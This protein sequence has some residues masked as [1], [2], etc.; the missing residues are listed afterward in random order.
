MSEMKTPIKTLNGH[1]LEDTEARAK[2]NQLSEEID[3]LKGNGGGVLTV[4]VQSISTFVAEA[5]PTYVADKTFAEIEAAFSAG[6][7]VIAKSEYNVLP[8]L[9]FAPG[10]AAMFGYT[11]PGMRTVVMIM[12]ADDKITINEVQA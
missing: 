2:V 9:M 12:G 8:L 3:T 6:Q 4:N 11:I 1:A 10:Q 5:T 7:Y